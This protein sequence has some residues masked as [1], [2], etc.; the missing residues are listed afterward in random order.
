MCVIPFTELNIQH[1]VMWQCHILLLHALSIL[2]S[3]Q[4]TS[5][6]F[7]TQTVTFKSVSVRKSNL[8]RPRPTPHTRMQL[9]G[10]ECRRVWSVG[11]MRERVTSCRT[12]SIVCL[13]AWERERRVSLLLGSDERVQRETRLTL[14]RLLSISLRCCSCWMQSLTTAPLFPDTISASRTS[15]QPRYWTQNTWNSRWS[16]QISNQ[17]DSSNKTPLLTR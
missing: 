16:N 17:T 13:W 4:Y 15:N 6:P 8:L 7:Q 3:V 11:S 12:S 10:W 2:C 14:V 1:K 5:S 9:I